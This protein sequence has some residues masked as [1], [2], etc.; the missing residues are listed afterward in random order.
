MST[1]TR[2]QLCLKT[3]K[4][5][6]PVHLSCLALAAVCLVQ[7]VAR[8]QK[9]SCSAPVFG[10]QLSIHVSNSFF[11]SCSNPH[12]SHHHPGGMLS[13]IPS[14]TYCPLLP[15]LHHPTRPS[16]STWLSVQIR[17]LLKIVTHGMCFGRGGNRVA[18]VIFE[19]HPSFSFYFPLAQPSL[20]FTETGQKK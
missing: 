14:P 8:H 10:M 7:D 3:S 12:L 5:A 20:G 1:K 11:T 9:L 6:L 18:C 15:P 4:Y 19:I 16:L 2:S 13:Y 17:E